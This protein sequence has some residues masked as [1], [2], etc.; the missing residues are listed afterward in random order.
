MGGRLQEVRLYTRHTLAYDVKVLWW[1]D[2]ELHYVLLPF[3]TFF[4]H[5]HLFS[6]LPVQDRSRDGTVMRALAFHQCGLGLIPRLVVIS[7]SSPVPPVPLSRRG[8]HQV[9][10]PA[11]K[12]ARWLWGQWASDVIS[13]LLVLVLAPR[14]F[15]QG[16]PV[17]SSHRKPT[18]PN[19]N[20]IQNLRATGLL[21]VTDFCHSH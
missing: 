6:V 13:L 19:S 15:R 8:L 17:F 14:S 5:I 11:V 4:T 2:V 10:P 9:Q 18:F 1:I 21:V 20:S 7:F 16:S 3:F 12:R